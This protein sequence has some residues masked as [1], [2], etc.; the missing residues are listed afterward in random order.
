MVR[1]QKQNQKMLPT[2]QMYHLLR[3]TRPVCRTCCLLR[4]LIFTAHND[5]KFLV[6]TALPILQYKTAL[7]QVHMSFISLFNSLQSLRKA[8]RYVQCCVAVT[9]ATAILHTGVELVQLQKLEVTGLFKH[10]VLQL[11]LLPKASTCKP[12]T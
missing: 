3:K 1:T 7:V 6:T 4:N 9:G 5:T 11:G 2:S 12:I 8:F 10:S